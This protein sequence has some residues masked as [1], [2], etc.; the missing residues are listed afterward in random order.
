MELSKESYL[1]LHIALNNI[2]CLHGY[3][4]AVVCGTVCKPS[5]TPLEYGATYVKIGIHF[6]Q[7]L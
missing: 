5:L 2:Q 7:K 3:Y 6:D 4:N 1:N